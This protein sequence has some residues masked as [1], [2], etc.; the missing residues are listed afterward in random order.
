MI[1]SILNQKGGVG[2]TT[3]V[4]NI[5]V[6]MAIKGYRTLLVDLDPQSNLSSGIG[7]SSED[8]TLS[9]YDLL[10]NNVTPKEIIK[11]TRI[12]NLDILPSKIELAGAE[13]EL[14]NLLSRENIFKKSI[15]TINE[16]YDFVL[17]DCPPSLG[18]L[19][20]NAL[21][22]A[23]KIII[24]VQSEYFALEGLGQLINTVNLVKNNLNQNLAIGGVIL[25]MFDQR[26]NLSRDVSEEI[27]KHFSDSVF[28]NFIP[29]NIRLS[30][31]PSRG[32]S[33]YEYAPNSSGAVA[34]SKVTDE[35]VEK[36]LKNSKLIR[37][38]LNKN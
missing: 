3:S 28:K 35:I 30:E 10:I 9:S 11:T 12:D 16:E 14:V 31:A 2:K 33:I 23:E 24:P 22:A 37:P 29:R 25:T 4:I 27:S 6:Y 15:A 21:S 17:V 26:T 8:I 1:I 32:L 20:V 38:I 18:L 5:G 13:V 7:L 19:T 34:Y 36:F